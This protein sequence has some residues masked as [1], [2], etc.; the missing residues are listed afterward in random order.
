MF[1]KLSNKK[2]VSCSDYKT[3]KVWDIDE[4]FSL[5]TLED[6]KYSVYSLDLSDLLKKLDLKLD[7]YM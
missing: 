6:H 3:I 5:K 7:I 1:K 4:G 2:V